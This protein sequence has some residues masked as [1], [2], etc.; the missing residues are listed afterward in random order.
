[1]G[2]LTYHP[3]S[4]EPEKDTPLIDLYDLGRNAEEVLEGE[5]KIQDSQ[6]KKTLRSPRST[7]SDL[8]TPANTGFGVALP[9]FAF[10]QPGPRL[11]VLP[12]DLKQ[13]AL[14]C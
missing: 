13:A 2:S 5:T 3:P 11:H 9:G 6:K 10:S 1:M 7:R 14:I 12:L 8:F 4:R